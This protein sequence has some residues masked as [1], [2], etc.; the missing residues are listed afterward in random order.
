MP[1]RG[2]IA[3]PFGPLYAFALL[4]LAVLIATVLAAARAWTFSARNRLSEIEALAGSQIELSEGRLRLIQA[5][6]GVGGF[7]WDVA[8]GEAAC[9]PEFYALLGLSPETRIDRQALEARVH[10]DD[11]ARMLHAIET[12]A[13]EGAAFDDECRIVRASDGAML[14]VACRA[15]P[16]LG[17]NGKPAHYIGVAID[18]T[19][20]KHAEEELAAAKLAAESANEAKSQF[21]ANMSHEL[22]TP[23]NAVIGYSE[24]LAEEAAD[25]DDGRLVPDL[26]KIEK[27]GRALLSLVNDVLDLSKIEAGKMDLYLE[28]FEVGELVD[29]GGLDRRAA[30]GPQ[31]QPTEHR[32]RRPGR[33]DGRPD[34]VP[35]DPAQPAQQRRQVH[36]GRASSPSRRGR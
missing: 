7:D 1:R 33:D 12:A 18:I 22:R 26:Q 20:R 11:R 27:A 32:G 29:G 5:A 2:P 28:T 15:R 10:I 3:R 9:S 17:P 30:D 13:A 35:A 8:R 24:M 14:W 4:G 21:L 31:R 6:G 16:M 34:Q 36:Q 23:L 19:D 25:V